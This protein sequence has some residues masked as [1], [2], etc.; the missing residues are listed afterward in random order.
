[1]RWLNVLASRRWHL[2]VIL[3]TGGGLDNHAKLLATGHNSSKI[4][5]IAGDGGR[6]RWG[7]CC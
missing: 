5:E 1:M 4:G 7:R 2:V 6:I 3:V